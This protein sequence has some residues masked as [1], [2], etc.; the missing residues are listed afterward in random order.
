VGLQEHFRDS[1]ANAEIAVGL[2]GRVGVEQVGVDSPPVMVIGYILGHEVKHMCDDTQGPIAVAEAETFHARLQ[3]VPPSPLRSS[4]TLAALWNT[5]AA[6]D[7]KMLP[8][9]I[10]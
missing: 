10:P 4:E 3:P 8:G 2:E 7:S 9:N 1:G 6:S 5:V